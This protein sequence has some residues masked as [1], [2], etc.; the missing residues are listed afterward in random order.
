M[1]GKLPHERSRL[2][3]L[4]EEHYCGPTYVHWTLTLK[5]RKQGWLT[6]S[7]HLTFREILTHSLGRFHLVCPVY[8][9]M[10]DHVHLLWVGHY[11]HSDQRKAMTHFRKATNKLLLKPTFAW[12]DQPYDHVLSIEERE[13]GAF[14]IMAGYIR[15]NPVQ[16]GLVTEEEPDSYRFQGCLIPGYP[17]L[18]PSQ[19]NYWE[20]F[21]RIYWRLH[22]E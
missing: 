6:D 15:G 7:W 13:K 10:P 17:D 4:P 21:W 1:D 18:N 22:S 14:E 20:L 5:D 12:Q 16:P 2:R 11:P 9:L 8:C 19:E 3:R